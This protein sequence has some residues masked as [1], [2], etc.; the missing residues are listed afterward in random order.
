M[1]GVGE[2]FDL[3]VVFVYCDIGDLDCGG[4]DFDRCY[5]EV[6]DVVVSVLKEFIVVV[7]GVEVQCA[8]Y[9][10]VWSIGSFSVVV[11]VIGVVWFRIV[12]VYWGSVGE[13]DY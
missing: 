8:K 6:V 1:Y 5:C 13:G 3:C 7:V 12:L 9:C 4:V 11:V 2:D 10:V